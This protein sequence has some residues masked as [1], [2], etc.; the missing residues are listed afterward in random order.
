PIQLQQE[1]APRRA[2]PARLAEGGHVGRDHSGAVRRV[3]QVYAVRPGGPRRTRWPAHLPRVPAPGA[4]RK[5]AG[6][7]EVVPDR[8]GE[9]R[10]P[11]P[12]HRR[13]DDPDRTLPAAAAVATV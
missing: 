1:G 9:T 10:A 8:A 11:D 6:M 4:R 5:R 12:G 3:R 7:E 2:A 13:G